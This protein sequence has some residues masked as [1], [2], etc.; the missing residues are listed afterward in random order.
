MRLTKDKNGIT[1]R[2]VQEQFLCISYNC[3]DMLIY[4]IVH[5]IRAVVEMLR[6]CRASDDTFTPY[7]S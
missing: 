4:E 6:Q 3:T 7:W 5:I 2:M 1:T